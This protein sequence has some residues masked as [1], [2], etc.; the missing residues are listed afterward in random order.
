MAPVYVLR[1]GLHL[2]CP[3]DALGP[4]CWPWRASP[5]LTGSGRRS[6]GCN[7]RKR[8]QVAPEAKKCPEA[9]PGPRPVSVVVRAG[10]PLEQLDPVTPTGHGALTEESPPSH[11]LLFCQSGNHIQIH[12]KGPTR[13]LRCL[14]LLGRLPPG[15]LPPPAPSPWGHLLGGPEGLGA[16]GKDAEG[17]RW[18][19]GEARKVSHPFS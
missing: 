19:L 8:Q 4:G 2:R 11:R 14:V 3:A 18:N 7:S 16:I 10:G 6:A 17:S 15:V 5:L 9:A 1:R 12:D 13:P